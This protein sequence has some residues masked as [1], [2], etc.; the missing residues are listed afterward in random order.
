MCAALEVN[1]VSKQLA[2]YLSVMAGDLQ[3]TLR[4][5][6]IVGQQRSIEKSVAPNGEGRIA[7]SNIEKN[8]GDGEAAREKDF[9]V[10]AEVKSSR[11]IED[12]RRTGRSIKCQ[13]SATSA[14][15]A[16]AHDETTQIH[17]IFA[18][19]RCVIENPTLILADI[20]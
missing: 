14:I 16:T 11:Y 8:I 7:A 12:E 4:T 1:F 9:G 2:I 6:G 3:G 5:G 20:K 13:G 18:A 19:E 10:T 15:V 17:Y